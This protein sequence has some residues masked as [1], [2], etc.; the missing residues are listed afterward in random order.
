MSRIPAAI[1]TDV[2]LRADRKGGDLR[3]RVLASADIT[4]AVRLKA[5]EFGGYGADALD[6]LE[7]TAGSGRSGWPVSRSFTGAKRRRVKLPANHVHS[8][9]RF[10][11]DVRDT[12]RGP[13]LAIKNKAPYAN[14]IVHGAYY[15]T[16]PF[17]VTAFR[18]P[19]MLGIPRALGRFLKGSAGDA[20]KARLVKAMD[21]AAKRE[22]LEA[23]RRAKV[24][25]G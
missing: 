9:D 7:A 19:K 20:Q 15:Q 21:R 2:E 23:R 14:A 25:G 22:L 4:P 5:R 24:V 18:R 10:F 1:E 11:E 6:Y 16:G 8:R 13:F 3:T 12:R 17:R